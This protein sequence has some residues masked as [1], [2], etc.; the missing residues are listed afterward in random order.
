MGRVGKSD[1]DSAAIERRKLSG[2]PQFRSS[3]RTRFGPHWSYW[4]P[5]H[6][7]LQA[8]SPSRIGKEVIECLNTPSNC[9]SMQTCRKIKSERVQ[10]PA[11]LAVFLLKWAVLATCWPVAKLRAVFA[12]RCCPVWLFFCPLASQTHRNHVLLQ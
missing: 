12:N 3:K 1:T 4:P 8:H 2:P 7:A 11:Q 10:G 9:K 5:H 6:G